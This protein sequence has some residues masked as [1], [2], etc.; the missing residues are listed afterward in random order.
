MMRKCSIIGVKYGVKMKSK[1]LN[2]V[3]AGL[4]AA[5]G[6]L[7]FAI[8]A[9]AADKTWQSK[10]IWR[11]DGTGD[12][13]F[14]DGAVTGTTAIDSDGYVAGGASGG[15][16]TSNVYTAAGTISGITT[17]WSCSAGVLNSLEVSADGTNYTAVSSGVETTTG[18]GTGSS[19]TYRATLSSDDILTNVNINYT[20]ASG[21]SYPFDHANASFTRTEAANDGDLALAG[22]E[23]FT[24]GSWVVGSS[25]DAWSSSVTHSDTTENANGYIELEESVIDS[26]DVSNYSNYIGSDTVGAAGG[27][28]ISISETRTLT[29]ATFYLMS[30]VGTDYSMA[31][32]VWN[33]SGTPGTDGVR[34]G[35]ALA[36][37]DSVSGADIP[38]IWTLIN[39]TF[40]TPYQLQAGTNYCV[41]AELISQT[42]GFPSPGYDYSS[43][44]HS[45][46]FFWWSTPY[47]TRDSIFYL[48]EQHTTGTITTTS[49]KDAE[50]V[51]SS[52]GVW[53]QIS[54]TGTVDSPT[55]TV[56]IE[57]DSSDDNSAWDGWATVQTD[58]V[59]GTTYDVPLANQK[60]YGKWRL[61]LNTSDASSIPEV[62]SVTFTTGK[63]VSGT[64]T[65]NAETTATSVTSITPTFKGEGM[66][67]AEYDEGVGEC[68]ETIRAF[69]FRKSIP[70]NNSGGSV[71][72]NYQMKLL[73]GKANG[74]DGEDFDL[75]G[76]C[77]DDFDDIR[78]TDSSATLL[79]YWVESVVDSGTS[80]LATVWV[81]IPN[82]AVADPGETIYIYYGNSGMSSA[83][84]GD[85]AFLLFDDFSGDSVDTTKWDSTETPSVSA[86]WI[87]LGDIDG[88]TSKNEVIGASEYCSVEMYINIT[89][90][91]AVPYTSGGFPLLSS[92][93][94]EG[95]L[96]YGEGDFDRW[97]YFNGAGS[98]KPGVGRGRNLGETRN[99]W[100]YSSGEQRHI[101][102]G[103]MN[104][105]DTWAGTTS[106]EA[107]KI[108]LG[109]GD[110]NGNG[111]TKI[112]W[113][114]VRK[115]AATE[116][117]VDTVNI[118][119]E[120]EK[121]SGGWL[122]GTR[123]L[124]HFNES[125]GTTADNATGDANL[126]GTLTN[127]AGTEWESGRFSNALHFDGA[128][129]YV[130]VN[131]NAWLDI[132]N[133]LTLEAWI[134][135]DDAPGVGTNEYI[136]YRYNNYYL[137]LNNNSGVVTA[138]GAVHNG[139]SWVEATSSDIT[140]TIT[141]WRHIG[142]VFNKDAGSNQV[143]LFLDGSEDG[144]GTNTTAIPA[145]D[146][147]LYIG[148]GDETGAGNDTPEEWFD[149]IIDEARISNVARGF[150]TVDISANAGANYKTNVLSAVNYTD[151]DFTAG[152]SLKY[153][154]NLSTPDSTRSPEVKEVKLDWNLNTAPSTPTSLSPSSGTYTND[155]TPILS[156]SVSDPDGDDV[157][158][159]F[160]IT[161]SDPIVL[162]DNSGSTVSGSGTSSYIPSALEDGTY[163]WKV[164]SVDSYSEESSYSSEN[165]FILETVAP[166][167]TIGYYTNSGCT[168]AFTN[169]YMKAGTYYIKISASEAL[170]S[171]PTISIAAEGTAND[172]TDAATA[173][174][175][176]N[177]YVYTRTISSDA[178]AVGSVA[179]VITITG[180]DTTGNAA[181]NAAVTGE[182]YTDTTVPASGS[183][184]YTG[185][186]TSSTS[187]AITLSDGSDAGGIATK[188]LQRAQANYT[189]STVG[190]FAA[191]G[192]LASSPSSPYTDSTLAAGKAYKFQYVITDNAGNP[193][194]YTSANIVQVLGAIASYSVTATTPQTAGTGW[195]ET[196]TALDADGNTITTDSS[197]AVTMTES[198][199]AQFYN[200][201]TYIGLLGTYSYR[202][203]IP[204][205]NAGASDLTNY[206]VK[207][208]I[209][210]TNGA[211][212]ENFDLGENCQDDF[213]D[214]RF[215]NS[216]GTL[217]DYWIETV[218]DSGTSK[219]AT[220]WVEVDSIPTVGVSM[221]VYYSNSAAASASS[222]DNTFIKDYS[223]DSG[224]V[225]QWLM[226]EGSGTT[227][228]DSSANTNT[229]TLGGDGAGDDLPSWVGSDGGVSGIDGTTTFSTG[230]ALSFDGGDYVN[231]GEG[232]FDYNEGTIE[233]WI[234][235]P[236]EGGTI[237]GYNMYASN[238]DYMDFKAGSGGIYFKWRRGTNQIQPSSVTT[239][240]IDKWVHCVITSDGSVY[241]M[242]INGTESDITVNE[243]SN[244]GNWFADTWSLAPY[245]SD[246]GLWRR[247]SSENWFNGTIGAVRIYSRDL[248]ADEITAHYE[249]RKYTVTPP[250][251]GAIGAQGVGGEIETLSLSS[252]TA[253]VYVKDNTAETITITAT[254]PNAKTGTSGSIVVNSAISAVST[255]AAN[256]TYITADVIN[257]TV[258]FGEA[259][260]VTGTPQLEF[261]TGTTDTKANYSSGTGTT[262]LTFQYTVQAGDNSSDLTYTGTSA[263]TLNSGT[264]KDT[265]GNT[266]PLT[267]PAPSIFAAAHAIVIEGI[268]PTVTSV[269]Q[270]MLVNNNGKTVDVLFSEAVNTSQ[271]QTVGN[272]TVGTATHP[273]TAALQPD[274][275]TVRLVFAQAVVPGVDVMDI[276]GISDLVGNAMAAV[277][278]HAIDTDD[279]TPPTFSVSAASNHAAGDTIVLTFSETMNTSTLT[280][281]NVADNIGLDYS[282][283]PGNTNEQNITLVNATVAWTVSDTVATITLNEPIDSVYIPHLKFIGVTPAASTIKDLA[284][285]A[286]ASSEIYSSA[287]TAETNSP[288]ITVTAESI[289]NGN[290]II[291]ITSNEVLVAA[292]GT[293]T[294]WTI[295]Y[296]DDASAGGETAITATNAVISLESSEKK[297]VTITLNEAADGAYLLNA[298]YIKATPHATNITDLTGNA[299]IAADYTAAAVSGESTVPTFTVSVASNHAAGDTIE[300][301]F[302]EIMDVSTLTNDNLST[303]ITIFHSQFATIDIQNITLTNAT[304]AWTS[305]DTVATITLNEATDRAY[306]PDGRYVG[307]TPTVSAIT[308]LI[309]NAAAAANVYTSSGV[310][311][312]STVPVISSTVPANST[313]VNNSNVSYTLSEIGGAGTITWERTGGEADGTHVHTL[314]TA[315][316]ASGAHS[317]LALSDV[318][319]VSGAIYTVTFAL[320]DL[321]GNAAVSV[322]NTAVTY[323][324]NAPTISSVTVASSNAVTT[325][326]KAG[327]T[328]TYS[329]TYSKAVTVS[330]ITASTA[331]NASTLTTEVSASNS[332]S[333]TL[334][335]TVATGNNGVVEPNNINFTITDTA[336]NT[337]VIP[338]L[339]TITGSV[340]ADTLSPTVGIT[341]TPNPTAAQAAAG[342]SFSLLFNETM[343]TSVA[344]IVSY[345]PAGATTGAQSCTGG[346]W[347][348][349][350]YTVTNDY[351][352]TTTTGD[353]AAAISVSG[354]RDLAGNV[355]SADTDDTFTIT[356]TVLEVSGITN[357]VTAG[358]ASNVL[359]TAKDTSGNIRTDYTG[360]IT[361][362][363]TDSAAVL[364]ANYTF[365]SG[366][367]GAH[368]FTNG[369]TLKT[370]GSKAVTATD[371]VSSV[372]T[373]SQTVTVNP[374]G[375]YKYILTSPADIVAGQ[376][377]KYTVTRYDEYDNLQTVGN[378]TV[379]LTSNNSS[380][381]DLFKDAA[382][383]GTTI[384]TR[385]LLNSSSSVDFWYYDTLV[386]NWTI[387]VSDAAPADAETG[388]VDA[389]DVLAVGHAAVNKFKL[390]AGVTSVNAGSGTTITVTAYD[391]YDN[392]ATGYGGASPGEDKTL[393]FSGA[394]A[395]T[396]P[397]TNPTCTNNV[398]TATNFGSDTICT[399]I[400]GVAAGTMVLYKAEGAAIKAAS[401]SVETAA[402][403]DLEIIANGGTAS[404]LSWYTQ[405]ETTA[406]ANAPWKAFAVSVSDSYGNVASSN[407]EITLTS[408]EGA[409]ISGTYAQTPQSGIAT[410]NNFTV[411]STAGTYPKLVTLNASAS[412]VTASDASNSV[413]IVERYSVTLNVA[414]S[415][416]G[417]A[418]TDVTLLLVDSDGNTVSIPS[419]DN[420]WTGNS[421]FKEN[422][423]LLYGTYSLTLTKTN[424]VEETA[425]KVADVAA[426]S[427]DNSYDNDI[428]WSTT[429]TSISESLADYVV[430]SDFVYDEDEDKLKATT[431][432]ERRGQLVVSSAANALGKSHVLIYDGTTL[433]ATLPDAA[434]A[435]ADTQGNFWFELSNVTDGTGDVTLDSGKTY[436]AKCDVSYWGTS[437][438]GHT[439]YSGTTFSITVAKQIKEL[440]AQITA[441]TSTIQSDISTVSGKVDTVKSETA[442]I[443]TDTA[444]T[445]PASITAAR[446]DISTVDTVVDSILV[447][448]ATTLPSTVTSAKTEM[449]H[450]IESRILNQ[451]SSIK[452]KDTL[453]IRYK[454]STG[455]FPTI[456]VYDT[457]N[458]RKISAA[459]MTEAVSGSGIYKY[460]VTF[461]WG[462]GGHTIVCKEESLSTLDGINIQV[463]STDLEQIGAAATTTMGQ[464]SGI[465]TDEI[466]AASGAIAEANAAISSVMED[467]K[468][469]SSLSDEIKGITEETIG[470]IYDS[471]SAVTEKLKAIGK[472]QG[473]K[474]EE[475]YDLSEDQA[476]NVG[477]IKN[478]T[479]EIKAMVELQKEIIEREN[480]QPITK[481]WFQGEAEKEL[482]E[483]TP[484]AEAVPESEPILEAEPE[485]E[486]KELEPAPEPAPEP[487]SELEQR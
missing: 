82:T 466:G 374:T 478:K 315:E 33:C 70:I 433:L 350:T 414:D 117:T 163:T 37:S 367:S 199:S 312:E 254:D 57:V 439:Y 412:G 131:D 342:L 69:S 122:A 286:A 463:I 418:L 183:I 329:I 178:A 366:D 184:S 20:D 31:A 259:V 403:D 323:D 470:A 373:G 384:T 294:N 112:D 369:V 59:S 64:Y 301:T 80:K 321:V 36:T 72:T 349:N 377:A 216:G 302:S 27:Q 48:Y 21:V 209:G 93:S 123:A 311:K 368:T 161:C 379:Y 13:T 94:N 8:Q 138:K 331:Y 306:I 421:P 52:G 362:T 219:L 224:L 113:V 157:H 385:T 257:I 195:T 316:L 44:T 225:T 293:I 6:V 464:V 213:D 172:I 115:Y 345:D 340:T 405:P 162:I 18:F 327:D 245:A 198:G 120:T 450:G 322:S 210:K 408:S 223:S 196:V 436:F 317:N 181:T 467:I 200:D 394:N 387:T 212:G 348:G 187:A 28:A 469:L 180:T 279:D 465:D 185:G 443:L 130:V 2:I 355:M 38:F 43:P 341:I 230:D 179:E 214:I 51:G 278:D 19:L 476:D 462:Q 24:S 332:S 337:T 63:P 73:I 360:T 101:C 339:G 486:I 313:T 320:T 249:R 211:E 261:E 128:A 401:G 114:F 454:T 169:S 444:T 475:M 97:V 482:P 265:N 124:W 135:P 237:F 277:T 298:K 102:S 86:G 26:Y 308:D 365:V 336:G 292:A 299:Q 271:A 353:G 371:T 239:I 364:P 190:S 110:F 228:A 354:A 338:S 487:D 105:D 91:G 480:D 87:T 84:N 174:L 107:K 390:T 133:K 35:S 134:N 370:T 145:S 226:D 396:S 280:T 477:Y 41:A 68:D 400:N 461:E 42:T 372:I 9:Q 159:S 207:L 83:S 233:A 104:F 378:E 423:N 201:S 432:L 176:G 16:Y 287:V 215:T 164:K 309:G 410:F 268:L 192:D 441:Q 109:S 222:F 383:E 15:T 53:K 326:A 186:D 100:I 452:E 58:A 319:L 23:S 314:T 386:G 296:D 290:D 155:T 407:P 247:D 153:K 203:E 121:P 125:S 143:K 167:F 382:S 266:T 25:G 297:I 17:A 434:G 204:L 264:I 333:D 275:I 258:T 152:T 193:T 156:A 45:G 129:D 447:D 446:G 85:N 343:Y 77:Q 472:D 89:D 136:L 11:A 346:S 484:E 324:L 62:E 34:T 197:T 118:G 248:S 175:S 32:K 417:G 170:A 4:L 416:T 457:D 473:L 189:G 474:I 328:V 267:L 47:S 357:P 208:L 453:T 29:K 142:L 1:I 256:G 234:N 243:G 393:V 307:I 305:G 39:F 227:I 56:N 411:Y 363:S 422:F 479:S 55:T 440:A 235:V 154:L 318:T 285:N 61:T 139:S 165:T 283:D 255:V 182:K 74:A 232:N 263:L 238:S 375:T 485:L 242:Y 381:S 12:Y 344:P 244:N 359:V 171:A 54:F 269:I 116:P 96:W 149:G 95:F 300:L 260:N 460:D 188:T 75:A 284:N 106:N 220:V 168:A 272:Y 430:K 425:S 191:F 108:G 330:D 356:T 389:A 119:I 442:S 194:T 144:T 468:G 66:Y 445:I 351:A 402:A 49:A 40:S 140:S 251:L 98:S 413:I 3:L 7:V 429:M 380:D 202:K 10:V 458:T 177:D 65:S 173:S 146:K 304:V 303:N 395:S 388:I 451:E 205:N 137:K 431:R 335:F 240:E 310:P 289:N 103:T 426:D 132:A 81:E 449:L 79:D 141:N 22:Y 126:D 150:F 428:T 471:L 481:S 231:C 347:S 60:Q 392:V 250:T 262:T 404:K 71:Q 281:S 427:T 435:S 236:G 352:I 5:G 438:T 50:T 252:G 166:T 99:T 419:Q 246:I 334:V 241:R 409:T 456:D 221:Y 151:S 291:T 30:S 437:G 90:V 455:L 276:S 448:T 160:Y 158:G 78:F 88:I 459:K 361:F 399:F 288:T 206:Q 147:K 76:H 424:Y 253:T 358:T 282:D 295:E 273:A 391:T 92:T 420:P 14:V 483:P 218:A 217:L 415:V 67:L 46:N 325:L 148:A 111:T 398:D 274:T 127:M 229:G 376:R 406:V 397:V 270:K